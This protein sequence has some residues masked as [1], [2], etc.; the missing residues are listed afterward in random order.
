MITVTAPPGVDAKRAAA[1][2]V[3]LEIPPGAAQ[4][5]QQKL[6]PL[7]PDQPLFTTGASPTATVNIVANGRR[8]AARV[9]V[10][11]I[12]VDGN[13]LGVGTAR[14]DLRPEQRSDLS[15][16]LDPLFAIRQDV[17]L[18]PDA[19]EKATARQVASAGDGRFVVVWETCQTAE[20][21]TCSVS[22]QLYANSART[23]QRFLDIASTAGSD[24]MPAVAML[25]GGDFAAVW[26]RHPSGQRPSIVA[27][28]FSANGDELAG[29]VVQLSDPAASEVTH[30]DIVVLPAPDVASGPRYAAVWSQTVGSGALARHQIAVAQV[31][32]EGL[33]LRVVPLAIADQTGEDHRLVRP[34]IAAGPDTFALA[35]LELGA[36]T[37]EVR[38]RVYSNSGERRGSEPLLLARS[39]QGLASG[40]DLAPLPAGGYLAI[41]HDIDEQGPDASGRGIHTRRFSAGPE[42][43]DDFEVILNH[44]E[45]HLAAT[46]NDQFDPVL[47]PNGTRGLL[48]LWTSQEP[49]SAT[50]RGLRLRP[51]GAEGAPN[52]PGTDLVQLDLQ[53]ASGAT[54][55]R[56][57]GAQRAAACALDDQHV[58]IT[59]LRPLPSDPSGRTFELLGRIV[60]ADGS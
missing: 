1:L 17:V 48:A 52:G 18:A 47:S 39:K 51:I 59:F 4:R 49:T 12:D 2:L 36:G 56:R 29:G 20:P 9:T 58:V 31:V 27:S 32:P 41:W 22:G 23:K 54:D 14:H 57:P 13:P 19:P 30:P 8:G 37:A 26:R 38:V 44:E 16:V 42:V 45:T 25:P 3:E 35:W 28:G 40:L 6:V 46:E 7:L 60:N 21:V 24:D 50:I 15:I 43:L 11:V 33:T 5:T 34:A 55:A 53:T 10:Q